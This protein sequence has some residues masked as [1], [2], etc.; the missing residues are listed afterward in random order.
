LKVFGADRAFVDVLAAKTLTMPEGSGDAIVRQTER[1]LRNPRIRKMLGLGAPSLAA[2]NEPIWDAR[3]ATRMVHLNICLLGGEQARADVIDF[4][5]GLSRL[6][7]EKWY[8]ELRFS[9]LYET[10]DAFDHALRA[11][12][13]PDLGGVIELLGIQKVAEISSSSVGQDFRDWFWSQVAPV[14]I[15]VGDT[16]ALIVERAEELIG[17]D[18]RSLRLA[19]ELKLRMVEAT[20]NDYVLGSYGLP[21]RR[22][23]SS[24]SARGLSVL[25]KQARIHQRFRLTKIEEV[26]KGSVQPYD[27]CP[28]RSGEKYR[29][30][31]GSPLGF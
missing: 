4:E 28:C 13:V 24:R 2:P 23:F 22:G 26:I 19:A 16:N 27:P 11:C 14:A 5:G 21:S 20:G 15:S 9:R 17:I 7:S 31:C 3:L 8:D 30:C 12:G 10:S 1:G 18:A 25:E 6:A 29:F